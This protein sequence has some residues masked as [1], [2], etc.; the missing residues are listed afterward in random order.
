MVEIVWCHLHDIN[1][2]EALKLF[3][4]HFVKDVPSKKKYMRYTPKP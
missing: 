1:E 2:S 4:K 3:P